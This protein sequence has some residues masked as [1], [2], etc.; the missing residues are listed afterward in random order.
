MIVVI[1]M[2]TVVL[3]IELNVVSY[4]RFTL[5]YQSYIKFIDWLLIVFRNFIQSII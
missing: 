2:M 4:A 5:K 3:T 1:K